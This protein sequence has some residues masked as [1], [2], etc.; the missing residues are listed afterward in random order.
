MPYAPRPSRQ[1]YPRNPHWPAAFKMLA[2]Y[3]ELGPV[4]DVSPGAPFSEFASTDNGGASGG[5][6]GQDGRHARLQIAG[7]DLAT[8]EQHDPGH[9]HRA[10]GHPRWQAGGNVNERRIHARADHS[11]HW[12]RQQPNQGRYAGRRGEPLE[13]RTDAEWA[14]LHRPS[15]TVLI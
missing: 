6:L 3:K 11:L 9:V 10:C 15:V 4:D 12:N 8:V 1:E 7:S 13:E 5:A 14:L 2:Y